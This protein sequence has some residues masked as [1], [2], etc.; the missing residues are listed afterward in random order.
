MKRI[1]VIAL[2]TVMVL[3]LVAFGEEKVKYEKVPGATEAL[4]K[5]GKS[6]AEMM[7][8][9]REETRNYEKIRNAIHNGRLEENQIA[10]D[11]EKKY[12]KPV[13]ILPARKGSLER[14]VYKPA[15]VSFFSGQKIYLFFNENMELVRWEDLG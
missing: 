2:L 11:I 5:V 15:E 14:W 9:A 7:Q 10:Q 12:G 3:P 6:Q 13:V 8:V 1:I 4:I